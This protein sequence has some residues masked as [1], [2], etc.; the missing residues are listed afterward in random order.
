MSEPSTEVVSTRGAGVSRYG[1]QPRKTVY[2]TVTDVPPKQEYTYIP[3][4]GEQPGRA[5]TF[6]NRL[7]G[8]PIAQVRV[9]RNVPQFLGNA[10]IIGYAWVGSMILIGLDEWHNN[11]ILPRPK[12]LWGASVVF[13]GLAL[14]AMV[15]ALVPIANAFAI[16]YFIMLIWQYYNGQG[17]FSGESATS[18]QAG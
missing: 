10:R 11:G 4:N 8:Q 6:A 3:N 13:G 12:R 1:N 5:R 15:D 9:P 7:A 2:A 17:Q 14:V 16:G 18:N